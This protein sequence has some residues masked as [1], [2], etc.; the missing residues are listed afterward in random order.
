MRRER[1]TG[2]SAAAA[3][4]AVSLTRT[5][6]QQQCESRSRTGRASAQRRLSQMLVAAALVSAC[7]TSGQGSAGSQLT[8]HEPSL[9]PSVAGD[10]AI[11]GSWTADV[12]SLPLNVAQG[13]S[14]SGPV[15]IEV[16]RPANA[17][18]AE[19]VV[20]LTLSC[21]L[22]GG[23]V[24]SVDPID[25]TQSTVAGVGGDDCAEADIV[26]SSA[27]DALRGLRVEDSGAVLIAEFE[28]SAAG[29]RRVGE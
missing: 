13:V 9:A 24:R 4:V 29:F 10:H 21:S 28:A 1:T 18:E 7:S 2:V 15:T 14:P 20:S 3:E 23:P 8:T 17:G 19:F 25:F 5:R 11:V 22:Y 12:S 27:I 26:A 16:A 6:V